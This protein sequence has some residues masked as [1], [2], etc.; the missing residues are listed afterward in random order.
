M[1]AHEYKI[2]V[3]IRDVDRIGK[4]VIQIMSSIL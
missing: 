1:Y 4:P 2:L 3:G